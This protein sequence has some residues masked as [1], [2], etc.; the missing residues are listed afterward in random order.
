M[1]NF[2]LVVLFIVVVV[3]L[4][5]IEKYSSGSAISQKSAIQKCCKDP[6]CVGF[7]VGASTDGGKTHQFEYIT[8]SADKKTM[9]PMFFSVPKQNCKQYIK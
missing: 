5:R 4:T 2:L 8:D 7:L 1:K 9:D 3:A 6:K